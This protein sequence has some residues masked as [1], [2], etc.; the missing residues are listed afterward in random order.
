MMHLTA[1]FET[2][3]SF[4]LIAGIGAL[5]AFKA[6][7]GWGLYRFWKARRKMTGVQK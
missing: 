3:V 6:A 1:L 5:W 2:F 4:G 7:I